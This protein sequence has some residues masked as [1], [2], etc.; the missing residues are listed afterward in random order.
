MSVHL[1]KCQCTNVELLTLLMLNEGDLDSCNPTLTQVF[2]QTEEVFGHQPCLWQQ[3]VT[4]AFLSCQDVIWIAGTGKGKT[5]TFW[6]PLLFSGTSIQ[7]IITPLN[8][9]G[10]Q[11]VRALEKAGIQAI[12][13]QAETA[14]GLNFQVCH[15]C[16][17]P[18]LRCD[19]THYSKGY[20]K[21][22]LPCCDNQPRTGYEGWWWIWAVAQKASVYCTHY[23]CCGWWG[24]L[25]QCLGRV[26][27]LVQR[28]WEVKIYPTWHPLSHC[29]SYIIIGSITWHQKATTSMEWWQD[30]YH[31]P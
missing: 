11:N 30:C 1:A 24:P 23:W 15:M 20:R 12:S 26:S 9:L 18:N 29:I 8:L 19:D 4:Q 17:Y 27:S 25:C 6:M 7:I 22:H 13:I 14:M 5:L 10:E 21:P 28:A 16:L 2:V 3:K 31:P